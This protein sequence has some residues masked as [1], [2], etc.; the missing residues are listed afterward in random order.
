MPFTVF[1]A[2]ACAFFN[3]IICIVFCVRKPDQRFE[4]IGQLLF[5]FT[6]CVFCVSMVWL[7][8]RHNKESIN[9]I[10]DSLSN[11]ERVGKEITTLSDA[12]A[13]R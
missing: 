3:I 12:L 1:A 13:D 8:S 7:Q 5:A 9:V 11:S 4:S 10:S 2:S 6:T